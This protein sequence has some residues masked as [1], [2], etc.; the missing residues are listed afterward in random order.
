MPVGWSKPLAATAAPSSGSVI[1]GA[2]AGG[3]EG[4]AGAALAEG[5]AEPDPDGA[6]EPDGAADPDGLA[7]PDGPAE[8]PAEAPADGDPA[9][10]V[11]PTGPGVKMRPSGAQAAIT[12][13]KATAMAARERVEDMGRR[14]TQ[15]GPGR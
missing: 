11:P 12:T 13:T 3:C 4:V 15:R 7:E 6:A 9:G 2:P 14:Y 8:P 10:G 1:C 5:A